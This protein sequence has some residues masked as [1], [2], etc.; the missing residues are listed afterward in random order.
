MVCFSLAAVGYELHPLLEGATGIGSNARSEKNKIHL[1]VSHNIEVIYLVIVRIE[2]V[3][4]SGSKQSRYVLRT[5]QTRRVT[6][7][8]QNS[9]IG[10]I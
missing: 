9:P 6:V 3:N 8:T 10:E 4:G 5:I 7:S 1:R 2:Y